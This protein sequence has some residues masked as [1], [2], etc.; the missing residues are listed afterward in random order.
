MTITTKFRQTLKGQAHKLK[1]VVMVGNKGVTPTVI[2]ELDRALN[3]HTLIKV[4]IACED[5]DERRAVFAQLCE[6]SQAEAVQL[7]GSIGVM[8]RKPSEE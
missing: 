1:P 5:R 4:R 8:Y 6:A 2:K 3:D 7:I